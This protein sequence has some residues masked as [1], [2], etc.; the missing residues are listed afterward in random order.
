MKVKNRD[1]GIALFRKLLKAILFDHGCIILDQGQWR[2][3]DYSGL[4]L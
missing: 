2:S 1:T 4:V 3:S